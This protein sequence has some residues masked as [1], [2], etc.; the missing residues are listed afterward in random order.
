[1][2]RTEPQPGGWR[3]RPMLAFGLSL[4][5]Y[6]AFATCPS[7][8][9][10]RTRFTAELPDYHHWGI[11]VMACQ[12]GRG[13]VII[14]DLHE[15]GLNPSPFDLPEIDALI[16]GY[17]QNALHLPSYHMAQRWHG[18]YARHPAKAFPG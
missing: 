3:L 16:L 2:M 10:L 1:M 17:L 9:D 6:P 4:A 8:P 12:N 5:H 15:Y 13:E 11:H 14:G 7:L 18:V